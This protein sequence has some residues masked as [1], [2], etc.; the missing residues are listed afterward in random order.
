MT[1]IALFYDQSGYTETTS[2]SADKS[3]AGPVGLMGREVA[4]REF[5]D[6][7]LTHGTW[8][9][10]VALTTGSEAKQS[11]SEFCVSHPSAKDRQRKVR[12][13]ETSR[14]HDDFL[15][16]PPAS[17]LHFPNPPDPNFAWARQTGQPHQFAFSGVTHTLCTARAVEVLRRTVTDPWEEYDRLICTST[18]VTRMVESVVD[19]YSRYLRDR[20]GG[21]PESKLGLQ[22]IPLGVN[23]DRFV[24][25]TDSER[26]RTRSALNIEPDEIVILFVGRLS[27]HAKAH[28][29]PLFRAVSK[30]ASQTGKTF[31]VLLCGWFP[32]PAIENAFRQAATTLADN[33][34]IDFVDGLDKAMRSD[35]WKCADVFMSLV[36]N[37]QETF[38]LVIV[39]A[40]AS[41]IPVI[42]SDWNGYRD[43]VSDRQTGFLVPTWSVESSV[44]DLTSR[45]LTGEINYDH[46]LARATQ[47]VTVST[48]HA[49]DALVTLTNDSDLRRRMGQA[50]RKRAVEMFSWKRIIRCYEAMWEEQ[51]RQRSDRQ[52][53]SDSQPVFQG[54]AP[55]AYPP[56]A[57]TFHG[58]PT[59]WLPSSTVVTSRSDAV[60]QLDA[61]LG[62]PLMTHEADTRCADH[63]TLADIIHACSSGRTI[64]QLNSVMASLNV[65]EQFH[66][67]TIA[68]ML[69]YDLLHPGDA[70]D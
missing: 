46:F 60:R 59:A 63:Q 57:A 28:P 50:G 33:I 69:K 8:N 70:V 22:T 42:A 55:A 65:P 54:A 61:V 47:A 40:M 30:A 18:A 17:I 11:L 38:G 58:Y 6:A 67:N 25:P 66:A 44:P 39:E 27:H 36:D 48:D 43:L 53:Q 1:P 49:T 26:E 21:Q 3:N 15:P 31:R 24:P 32:S 29:Y 5:L 64:A 4:G 68:W 56:V 12:F 35:I 2:R 62:L 16:Q 20:H 45:L 14:F 13:V 7:Y 19:N 9:E 34:R 41:G 51:D 23:T 37:I 52:R 10:L